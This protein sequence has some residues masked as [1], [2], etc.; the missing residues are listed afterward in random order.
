[1]DNDANPPVTNLKLR[2]GSNELKVELADV[3]KQLKEHLDKRWSEIETRLL[4]EFEMSAK[5][6]GL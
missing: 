2:A 4:Q 5:R 3:V 6:P 1:M